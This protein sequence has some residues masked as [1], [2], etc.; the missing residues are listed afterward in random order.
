[1]PLA[2]HHGTSFRLWPS[3]RRLRTATRRHNEVAELHEL[4]VFQREIGQLVEQALIDH[5]R[6]FRLV[7]RVG[8]I[9]SGYGLNNG[10]MGVELVGGYTAILDGLPYPSLDPW[11]TADRSQ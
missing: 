10:T 3:K 4:K 6:R 5:D 11:H 1:M 2:L 8:H 7:D 9:L